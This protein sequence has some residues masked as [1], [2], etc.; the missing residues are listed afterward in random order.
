MTAGMKQNLK[1][2]VV[3]KKVSMNMHYSTVLV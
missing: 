3:V 1:V 2:V